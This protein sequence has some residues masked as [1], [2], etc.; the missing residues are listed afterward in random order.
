MNSYSPSTSIASKRPYGLDLCQQNEILK[1][2]KSNISGL[3]CSNKKSLQIFQKGIIV[4]IL[5][6]QNLYLYVK[7][8]YDTTYILTHRL[9]QVC[10][11]NL[12]SQLLYEFKII[13]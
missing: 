4:S 9:N 12:F 5:S 1:D 13:L 3:L 11:E 6:L 10:L 8:R 7:E 2:M